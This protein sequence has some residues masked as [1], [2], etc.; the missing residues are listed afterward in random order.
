M[1]AEGVSGRS[2]FCVTLAC[3]AV[4]CVFIDDFPEGSGDTENCNRE[5]FLIS[6]FFSYFVT[7]ILKLS[8]YRVK[9]KKL[10]DRDKGKGGAALMDDQR[11][12]E[13]FMNRDEQAIHETA[14]K[15][16]AYIRK[17]AGNIL[18]NREDT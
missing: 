12:I 2:E 11:I 9:V 7:F 1:G 3:G 5:L 17:I 16:G 6:C 10:I 4:L 18:G 8:V 14:D 15:Y 13:L